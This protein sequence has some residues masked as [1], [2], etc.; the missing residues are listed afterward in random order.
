MNITS[1]NFEIN[2]EIISRLL[3]SGKTVVEVPVPLLKRRYGVSKINIRKE[4]TNYLLLMGKIFKT[5]YL[6]KEWK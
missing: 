3:I 1:N 5:K 4:I 2:A 6:Y